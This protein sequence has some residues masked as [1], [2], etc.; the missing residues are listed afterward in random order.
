MRGNI[1][2]R[3]ASGF[4]ILAPVAAGTLIG[5][6]GCGSVPGGASASGQ[7]SATPAASA[8]IPLCAAAHS[9]TRSCCG[10]PRARPV[11]C[12]RAR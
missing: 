12:S 2:A 11:R 10:S 8:G 4:A 3:R 6:A 5:L 7:A 1:G 9:W